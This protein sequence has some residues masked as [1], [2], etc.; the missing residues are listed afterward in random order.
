MIIFNGCSFIP[1]GNV[2]EIYLVIA[3]RKRDFKATRTRPD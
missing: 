3:A 1:P 2:F